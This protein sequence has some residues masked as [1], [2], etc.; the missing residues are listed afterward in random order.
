MNLSVK[1]TLEE[2]FTGVKKRYN[3]KHNAKCEVCNGHGGTEP[4]NCETC[5]GSGIVIRVL[6]T[7]IGQF[8]QPYPCPMCEGIGLKYAKGCEPCNN[9][10]LSSI[11]ETVEVDVP[12]GVQD[13]MTFIM[14]RKGHAIKGGEAGDLHITVMELPHKIYTRSGSDLKMKLKL[15]YSQL[16][17]GDKVEIDTIEGGKIR[18]TIP[19]HTDVDTTLR[20]Q[21]KGLKAYGKETRGDMVISLGIS[22]PK[23]ITETTRELLT[24]LK[25]SI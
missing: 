21:N 18:V 16:V 1:L 11:E 4:R 24:K 9:T 3:Y 8:R 25:N 12:S 22:I 7:N 20:A 19:E 10:G 5:H 14:P 15:T 6:N 23:Q 2:I 17:L 13:G